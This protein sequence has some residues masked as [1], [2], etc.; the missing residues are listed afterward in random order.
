MTSS[1]GSAGS[2]GSVVVAGVDLGASGGRVLAARVS[3]DGVSLHEV[4]RFPNEPVLAGGTLHWDIL[5]LY[6]SAAS[7]LRSAA[8]S[9]SLASAGIDSWGVDYGLLDSS[10]ALVGNPA[11]Y[12]DART[13]G[14]SVP[15]PAASL[16]AVTGIQHLPFNTI[17]QLA[18]SLGTP[19][20]SAA[21]TLLLIPDLLGYWLTGAVG[22]EVT[23]AS[24]T[25]L[26][27]VASRSWAFELMDAA[28]IP[29]GLFPPLLRAGR[30][31]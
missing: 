24:T 2:A 15:V 8:A 3:P 1:V 31:C 14:V 4:S 27:D 12:R 22:A 20:L 7:G 9:F 21:S 11:H 30:S 28:G 29:R 13:S 26:L 19:L 25:G 10:G 6:S 17:Y 23:N 18:A 16:Y 5:R